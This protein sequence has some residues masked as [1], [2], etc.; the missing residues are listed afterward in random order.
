MFLKTHQPSD[1][2]HYLMAAD[3][4]ITLNRSDDRVLKNYLKGYEGERHYYERA[5][6]C[7]G[8]KLWD[9]SLHSP[10]L[11]QFDFIHLYNGKV[12]HFDIKNYTG[13]VRRSGRQFVSEGEYYYQDIL[14]QLNRADFYL[15]RLLREHGF[16]NEV[17]S[18]IVFIHPQLTLLE[19]SADPQIVK[20]S[21][22]EEVIHF[23]SQDY[24]PTREEQRLA[25]F[26]LM[27]H[28]STHPHERIFY[29]PFQDMK[30]G[31]RCPRCRYIGLKSEKGLKKIRCQCGF[32]EHKKI[33][34]QTTIEEMLL[35]KNAPVSRQ[36]I[37]EWTAMCPKAITRVLKENFQ[38]HYKNRATVYSALK[39]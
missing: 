9:L 8:L 33:V 26:M 25:Q 38:M 18:R 19:D 32:S 28:Q 24:Q 2:I 22:V 34:L 7:G 29:Y 20:P 3:K 23:F 35:L 27:N 31:I 11:A 15:T 4:R 36:E 16:Q 5:H 10:A 13:T 17:V 1:Y 21:Q 12:Y 39:N 37:D 30:K 14:T 6:R